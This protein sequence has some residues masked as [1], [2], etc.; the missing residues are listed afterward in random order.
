MSKYWTDR[1][2]ALEQ[3]EHEKA[4]DLFRA[5]EKE[6]DRKQRDLSKIIE[7]WYYRFAVNNE[8]SMVD[9]RKWL[10]ED[11]LDEFKWD[12]EEYIEIG[13]QNAVNQRWL[14]ELE[15]ASA[16]VHINRIDYLKMQVQQQYELLYAMYHNDM[17]E[18][19]EDVSETIYYHTMYEVQK[20][21]GV[22]W[23]VTPFN[24]RQLNLI[25][26]KPWTVDDLTFSDRIWR[27]REKLINEAHQELTRMVLNGGVPDEAIKNISKKMNTSKHNAGRLVMTESAYIYS[28]SQQSAYKG[29]NVEKFQI[30]ATLDH[31]TSEICRK[32]DTKVYDMKDY[33]IGVTA[34]PFHPWCRTV[35]IPYFEDDFGVVGERAA[36]DSRG[37]T[38]LIPADISYNEWQRD[39]VDEAA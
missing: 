28:E 24:T 36:R 3:M 26:S 29:L 32:L 31:K 8:I 15:N 30:V 18:L 12:L 22:G 9:A 4:L 37:K 23:R 6:F 11:E 17:L 20:G 14:T 2:E 27:D 5:I 19:A 16:R 38:V 1:F 10:K 7:R 35:T 21:I 25:I 13:K 34:P 39:F 33:E